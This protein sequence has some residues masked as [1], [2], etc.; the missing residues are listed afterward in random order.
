MQADVV[1]GNSSDP[2]SL[3]RF[4]YSLNDPVDLLDPLGLS[5]GQITCFVDGSEMPCA[6]AYSLVGAGAAELASFI[7]G[8]FQYTVNKDAFY[9]SIQKEG[10]WYLDGDTGEWVRDIHIGV[11]FNNTSYES[12]VSFYLRVLDSRINADKYRE[13]AVEMMQGSLPIGS[14]RA[15]A[16]RL[17]HIFR[18]KAGHVNPQTLASR[19]RY[20]DLY[21]GTLLQSLRT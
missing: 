20:V 12:A 4:S 10:S 19:M 18:N 9:E 21:I 6:N 14:I 11:V 5:P 15:G 7:E 13:E 17:A 1:A 2:Q 3:N 16:S 8:G